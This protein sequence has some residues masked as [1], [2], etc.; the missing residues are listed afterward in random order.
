[1]FLSGVAG[2]VSGEK[3]GEGPRHFFSV[4]AI[5]QLFLQ[6]ESSLHQPENCVPARTAKALTLDFAFSSGGVAAFLTTPMDVLK[7]RLMTR[8]SGSRQVR[9]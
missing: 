3:E 8:P 6:G 5:C 9:R 1:M 2:M 7:T 4:V